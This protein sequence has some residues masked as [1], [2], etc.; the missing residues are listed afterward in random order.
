MPNTLASKL[1]LLDLTK[2]IVGNMA[3]YASGGTKGKGH[4]FIF[5]EN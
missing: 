2:K 3:V 1:Q 4:N 5:R